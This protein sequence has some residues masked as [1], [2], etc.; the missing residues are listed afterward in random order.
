M[1][2][3]GPVEDIPFHSAPG[4]PTQDQSGHESHFYDE[5]K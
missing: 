3:T 4:R 1:N 2:P 5:I